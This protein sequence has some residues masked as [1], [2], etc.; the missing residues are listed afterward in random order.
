MAGILKSSELIKKSRL[1]TA[2]ALTQ[3]SPVGDFPN[4]M[5]WYETSLESSFIGSERVD[6]GAITAWQDNNPNAASKNNATQSTTANQPIFYENIFNGGIP[7]VRFDGAND[8]LSFNGNGLI[9]TSYTIFVVE[10]KRATAGGGFAA[11]IGG[12]TNAAAQ[13]LF[14]GYADDTMMRLTHFGYSLNYGP[15]TDLAYSS[16]KVRIHSGRFNL[17]GG[18]SYW[19][20]GGSGTVSDPTVL[21]TL[22]SYAG[23]ALGRRTG[24]STTYFNGDLAEIIIYTR[25][26]KTEE[27]Q[28]V[29]TYLGKKY[30][31]GIG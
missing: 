16:P 19:L 24:S 31:V 3:N 14:F 23:S 30:G 10:Q 5:L 2:R 9:N 12:T 28:A 15:S 27:R 6:G 13:N 1:Q 26:L 17:S 7:S 21:T 4:L 25:A 29:E 18:M 8:Y 22:T 11:F 20:N